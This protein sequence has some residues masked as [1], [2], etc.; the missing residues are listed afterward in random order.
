MHVT[1][2]YLFGLITFQN[3][4]LDNK[5]HIKLRSYRDVAKKMLHHN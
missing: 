2:I 4:V 1:H 5:L 3:R